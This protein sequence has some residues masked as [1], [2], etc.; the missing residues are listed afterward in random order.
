MKTLLNLIKSKAKVISPPQPDHIKGLTEQQIIEQIHNEFFTEVDRLL[1][2]CGI[3]K[4]MTTTEEI[5]VDKSNRLSKLGFHN[6]LAHE[7]A[8]PVRQALAEDLGKNELKE[9]IEY[10]SNKYHQYKFITED[11][12]KT[13]C[14]KYNLYYGSVKYYIGDV[15]EKNLIEIENFKVDD[16]DMYFVERYPWVRLLS[17]SEYEGN[18]WKLDR[19]GFVIAAPIT[20]FKLDDAMITDRKI[21][22]S[23]PDPIVLQPVMYKKKTYYLVVTA[24]GAEASD[25]LVVNQ[26]MN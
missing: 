18:W 7:K 4:S 19:E 6:S 8:E 12:V 5:A 22:F 17:Y 15:P 14:D 3:Q 26:K 25:E 9:A 10:F 13:I 11:S 24:W 20:D 16:K 2:Y 23:V 1:E 21:S